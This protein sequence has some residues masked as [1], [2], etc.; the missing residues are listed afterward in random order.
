LSVALKASSIRCPLSERSLT[1][2]AKGWVANVVGQAGRLDNIGINTEAT[3]ELPANLRN[4]QGVR[5]TVSREIQ[6]LGRRE[7]LCLG[8]KTAER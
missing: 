1:V 2:V 7:D 4:F 3:S 6:S 8:C 5:Q